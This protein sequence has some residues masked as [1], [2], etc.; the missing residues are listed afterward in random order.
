MSALATTT[1]KTNPMASTWTKAGL[2]RK[3]FKSGR[4]RQ[5]DLKLYSIKEAG[6]LACIELEKLRTAMSDVGLSPDD[7]AAA[8]V[9]VTPET[10]GQENIVYTVPV[11]HE[12]DKLPELFA[13]VKQITNERFG[14]IMSLGIVL[15]QLDYEADPKGGVIVWVEPFLTGPRAEKA[16]LH[17]KSMWAKDKDCKGGQSKFQ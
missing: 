4:K 15:R 11:P 14:K 6:F 5:T 9:L 8:L 10:P 12:D 3:T 2:V 13:K 17:A 1:S 7:V 16:L